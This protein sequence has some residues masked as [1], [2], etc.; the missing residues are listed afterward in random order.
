[1]LDEAACIAE[2]LAVL[3]RHNRRGSDA[4]DAK[5]VAGLLTVAADRLRG[6]AN[7]TMPLDTPPDT[8]P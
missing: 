7:G 3:R 1:M 6:L 2:I 4:E 5:E 8:P